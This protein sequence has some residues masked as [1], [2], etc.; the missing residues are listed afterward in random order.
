MLSMVQAHS[1]KINP[2][3]GLGARASCPLWCHVTGIL[4]ALAQAGRFRA[5]GQHARA[6]VYQSWSWVL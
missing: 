6:P 2:V 1:G 3:G 4:P 5:S